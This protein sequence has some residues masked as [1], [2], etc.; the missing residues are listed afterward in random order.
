MPNDYTTRA[1]IDRITLKAF[2]STAS[3]LS[4]QQILDLAND[5]L[6]SYLVPLA[7]TLREEWWVFKDNISLTTDADGRITLPDSVAST[8]RTVAW[9]NNSVITPLTRI[10]P[11]AAFAYLNSTGNTP[12]GFELRGY[13]L[14]ILPPAPGIQLKLTAMRRPAQMVLTEDAGEVES[15]AGP[16]LTLESVPVA[17]QEETPDEVDL[18]SGTSP[19]S[20]VESCLVTSLVGNDLTLT[21]T[22]ATMPASAWV[23]DLDTSPFANIPIELY[24]LLEQDVI[25]TLYQGLGDKRLKGASERKAELE[26]MVKRT[27]APRTSGNARPILNPS[28]PG[29]NGWGFW[30]RR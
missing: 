19:F 4:E 20:Q 26:A 13:T 7:S 5:S 21:S 11:E 14:R 15:S 29:M 28:A 12:V 27:M 17:W 1:L 9:N 30:G 16:V 2:T 3:S 25:T 10:E 24:P 23:S 8:L 22:P 18:I 6:R